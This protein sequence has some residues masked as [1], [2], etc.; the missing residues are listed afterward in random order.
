MY[1]VKRAYMIKIITFFTAFALIL[2]AILLFYPKKQTNDK[3]QF[4]SHAYSAITNLCASVNTIKESLDKGYAAGDINAVR[5]SVH[6]GCTS[7]KLAVNMCG[8]PMTNTAIWFDGFAKYSEN[9]MNNEEKN[10]YYYEKTTDAQKLLINICQGFQNEYSI[11]EID[12]YFEDPQP[13]EYY[14]RQLKTE[15]ESYYLLKN[16]PNANRKEIKRFTERL[17]DTTYSVNVFKDNYTFQSSLN[18]VS[19]NSYAKIY[20]S[21]GYLC[22]MATSA[23]STQKPQGFSSPDNAAENYLKTLAPY[24]VNMQSV[25]QSNS[26]GII[27]YTFCHILPDGAVSYDSKISIALSSTNYKLL[28]FDADSYLKSYKKTSYTEAVAADTVEIKEEGFETLYIRKAIKHQAQIT[29]YKLKTADGRCFYR[30]MYPDSTSKLL[31]EDEYLSFI[32]SK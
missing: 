28:A 26:N 6:S 2:T 25:Y 1:I 30:L 10:E 17:F 12:D 19:S 9:E 16:Q 27:Y 7:A 21:G 24:A 22:F 31:T 13:T 23:K 5:L 20:P 14:K 4:N 8:Y 15:E 18:Y 29:E 3:K 11:K 32:I